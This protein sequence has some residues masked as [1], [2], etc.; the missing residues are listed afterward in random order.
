MVDYLKDTEI[1][2]PTIVVVPDYVKHAFLRR[3]YSMLA[4]QLVLT[5][6]FV[7]CGMRAPTSWMVTD[8]SLP[9]LTLIVVL[10][11][12]CTLQS[13]KARFPTN[14]MLLFVLTCGISITV[15]HAVVPLRH[16]DLVVEALAITVGT[17]LALTALAL[18]T[19]V[20][21]SFLGSWLSASLFMLLGFM[22]VQ[23]FFPSPWLHV[24]ISWA[25]VVLFSGYILYD[26]SVMASTM[27]PDDAVEACVNL[28][29]DIVNLFLSILSIL[30]DSSNSG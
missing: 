26:T 7:A 10:P 19:S 21:L 28:Y 4:V 13:W 2:I 6:G 29:L 11:I 12:L 8:P 16:P 14:I 17:F 20:N 30:M 15:T 18:Q 25:S 3:V 22:L 5:A 1:D 24:L 23:L 27:G 9:W